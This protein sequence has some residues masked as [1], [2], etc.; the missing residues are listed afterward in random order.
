[1][2]Y[3]RFIIAKANELIESEIM[4]R[5]RHQMNQKGYSD[6]IIKKTRV[7]NINLSLEAGQITYE[8]ISD[9]KSEKGFDVA[10]AREKG[11]RRHFIKPIKKKAL[12]WMIYGVKFFSKGHWV[13]G[14]E[15]T[16]IIQNTMEYAE[17]I[18]QY[19]LD[20]ATAQFFQMTMGR[21]LVASK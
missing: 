1:M 15:R 18:V 14:M 4:V 16:L 2:Q 12:F 10:K 9:Y 7:T 13:S 8:I 19:K 11:T 21:K 5:I 3:P 17:P 20:E 6:K